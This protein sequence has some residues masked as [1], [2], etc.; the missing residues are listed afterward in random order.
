MA[1][2]LGLFAHL[3][4]FLTGTLL[5]GFL[6]REL[7]RHRS[8]LP[9]LPMRL[10]VVCLTVWYGGCFL[11]D[12]M[13]ILLPTGLPGRRLAT[14]FDLFRAYAWLLSFPLL[15]HGVWRLLRDDSSPVRPRGERPPREGREGR[16]APRPGWGWLLPGYLTLLLFVP[17]ALQAWQEGRVHLVDTG[18]E[19]YA[20]VLLHAVVASAG[21]TWLLVRALREVENARLAQF[22]R[23]LL[24][25]LGLMIA[26]LVL[27][28]LL[29]AEEAEAGLAA[30]RGLWRLATEASG[31]VPGVTFLYF[32]QRY[33]LMRLSLSYRS[34]RHFVNLFA[35]IVLV[36]LAGPAVG[37]TGTGIYRR[38]VAWGLLVALL[39]GLIVTPLQRLATRRFVW[40]RRLLG[41]NITAEEIEELTRRIQSLDLSEEE[42]RDL[43]AR[44][45]G[46][47]LATRARFL[48]P[49][50]PGGAEPP[51]PREISLLWRH[52]GDPANR[53]FNRLDAPTAGLA[54]LL[55]RANLQAAFPLR[56]A[57][58]LVAVLVLE[59]SPSGSG[60][61]E[62]EVEAVQLVMRQLAAVLE[63]R[64]LAEARLSVERQMS[65]RERLSL[66]G[67]VAA[68]LAHE[69]KNPLSSMKAL[70][71]TVREE[72]T[73]ADPESEQA[74]DLSLIVEQIDRL[75]GVA[76]EI[77]DF[78]RLPAAGEGV[79]VTALLHS[80]LYVLGHQGRQR[81][82]QLDSAAVAEVGRVG[83][84]S[85]TWQTVLFNLILN[86]LQHAPAGSTVRIALR[87]EGEEVLFATEN[88][89]PAIAPGLARRLFEP[90]VTDG[91]TGLG[92]ALVA[93]R[94]RELGGRIDVENEPERIVFQVRVRSYST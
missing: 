67:M 82:I 75:H 66:L 93:Q 23:W 39:A 20:L 85:A 11:D 27:G 63:I 71:Q 58:E 46:E 56:V 29:L 86:A 13:G 31:L 6:M 59:A 89:G 92:L 36:M 3:L 81:G 62:G 2:D 25:G 91:G 50:A 47:W 60:F 70:A 15:T 83:G 37:V 12:V 88:G 64:R 73:A 77:L 28:A 16:A 54:S 30:G 52:F 40:L 22:L 32:V 8:V 90:F 74:Q 5:Y 26:L 21:T 4:L 33:N 45:I 78:A 53:T 18:R 94:V 42:T 10:L 17:A 7:F 19:V 35:L 38:F 24:G 41:Q 49:A 14:G 84:T 43:V 48:L 55:Q 72:L 87:R 51:P 44:E 76:R 61:E 79:L 9:G 68:S 65:E 57:G 34:L 69:L 80:T 1:E